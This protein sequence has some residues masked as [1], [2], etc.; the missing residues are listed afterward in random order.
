MNIFYQI[1]VKR[2]EQDTLS[3]KTMKRF[4]KKSESDYYV[5]R[6][7]V[8]LSDMKVVGNAIDQLALF[9]D[10]FD[11]LLLEKDQIVEQLDALRKAGN[12]KTVTFRQLFA[13][14]ISVDLMIERVNRYKKSK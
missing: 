3:V 5:E 4:T 12:T 1:C 7:E 2:K 14:K 10:F 6:D 13:N 11:G 8:R 9:E